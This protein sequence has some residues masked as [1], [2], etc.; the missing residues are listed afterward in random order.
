MSKRGFRPDRRLT[1]GFRVFISGTEQRSHAGGMMSSGSVAL[2]HVLD[3]APHGL[4]ARMVEPIGIE[5]MTSSL[6]S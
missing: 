3:R 1:G 4:C 6:Q 2:I 5:P